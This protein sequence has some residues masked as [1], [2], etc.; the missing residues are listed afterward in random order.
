MR[1]GTD[2]PADAIIR[3][4]DHPNIVID[5][6]AMG[7]P[8]Q[9]AKIAAAKKEISLMCCDSPNLALVVPTMSL[10]GHGTANMTGN[11]AP[12]EMAIISKPWKSFEDAINF[13]QTYL[14][15]LPLLEFSYSC[16]NPVPIKSLTKV[17]G[18]PS[19]DLRKPYRNLE[20]EALRKGLEIVKKLGLV[21]KYGYSLKLFDQLEKEEP[22]RPERTILDE[23]V[24][25]AGNSRLTCTRES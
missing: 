1:V 21:E 5:K 19:G 25:L 14:R 17:L 11:I 8:I 7:R 18:L 12:Q 2:L 24:S 4:A 20:G 23:G 22:G 13:R 16:I 6:E 10:G 3:L 9:I 15:I